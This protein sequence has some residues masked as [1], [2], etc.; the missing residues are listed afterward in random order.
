MLTLWGGGDKNVVGEERGVWDVDW[1]GRGGNHQ[2]KSGELFTRPL[3]TGSA[4]ELAKHIT[5][6]V[7]QGIRRRFQEALEAKKHTGHDVE[8]GR[9]FVRAYVEFVHY[10][11]RLAV[12]AT[13]NAAHAEPGEG[14][15]GGDHRHE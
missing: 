1:P 14:A 11:E 15:A 2:L 12:S 7:E 3:E 5:Q 4:D 13:T 9:E 8:A 6:E 10:V